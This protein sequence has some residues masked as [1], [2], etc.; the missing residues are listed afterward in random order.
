M[1][2]GVPIDPRPVLHHASVSAHLNGYP[3]RDY[4]ARDDRPP[5]RYT[6]FWPGTRPVRGGLSHRN[7]V[8]LGWPVARALF[9]GGR[10]GLRAT[11]A[12]AIDRTAS[13][14]SGTMVPGSGRHEATV[15]RPGS[16][17]SK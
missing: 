1:T 12:Q 15:T 2:A 5:E 16:T 7:S 9:A 6:E 3:A 8:Y 13:C 4:P 14:A 10:Y 11:P 17:S